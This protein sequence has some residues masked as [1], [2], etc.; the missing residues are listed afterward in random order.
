MRLTRQFVIWVHPH[1]Q[2]KHPAALPG[3]TDLFVYRHTPRL[4][5]SSSLPHR[6]LFAWTNNGKVLFN[7][8]LPVLAPLFWLTTAMYDIVWRQHRGSC[9]LPTTRPLVWTY[10]PDLHLTR[11][12]TR[13]R[14]GAIYFFK[15]SHLFL[16]WI[17]RYASQHIHRSLS[18]Q[19]RPTQAS[20][21]EPTQ[22]QARPDHPDFS[23][24]SHVFPNQTNPISCDL[25][26]PAGWQGSHCSTMHWSQLWDRHCAERRARYCRFCMDCQPLGADLL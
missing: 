19:A 24:L 16:S 9:G 15:S 13:M 6:L 25:P 4:R 1:L 8:I 23:D 21:W 12:P 22:T 7:P 20:E 26:G 11:V 17:T 5:V 2:E 18:D 10:F 14:E 3:M